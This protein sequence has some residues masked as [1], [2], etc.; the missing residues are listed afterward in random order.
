MS[1]VQS[2]DLAGLPIFVVY[3]TFSCEPWR[4]RS[5]QSTEHKAEIAGTALYLSLAASIANTRV[6]LC[7]GMAPSPPNHGP[8]KSFFEMASGGSQLQLFLHPFFFSSPL[9]LSARALSE[10]RPRKPLHGSSLLEYFSPTEL[11]LRGS[12][13]P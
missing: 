6:P 5:R 7:T 4:G 2:T 13:R 12:R 8:A 1:I 9:Y 3:P 11:L 10:P